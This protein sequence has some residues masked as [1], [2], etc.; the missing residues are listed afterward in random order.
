[1][2]RREVAILLTLVNHPAVTAD[3]AEDLCEIVISHPDLERLRAAVLDVIAEAEDMVSAQQ[4][5]ESLAAR[6]FAHVLER[7]D[8]RWLAR[9][10]WFAGPEAA[11]SDAESG[12]K[13]MLALHRKIN[14]LH[15]NLELAQAEYERD[16][17]EA[18]EARLFA[19]KAELEKAE[20]TE[21]LVEGFGA[22]SGRP[23]R[24][25]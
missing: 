11:E 20:G 23:V 18:N 25:F 5:R 7:L 17:T 4:M 24:S 6:G 9:A 14:T 22:Q 10:D 1:M 15:R 13:H 12:L 2:G 8:S 3:Y 21:A 19:I 16:I